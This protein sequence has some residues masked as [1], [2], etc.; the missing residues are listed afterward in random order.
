MRPTF[1]GFE[2]QKHT[3][4]IA[5][6]NLDIT[7][8]NISNINTPGYTRQR[9]DL[10]SMYVSGNRSLRW[11]SRTNNLS[12]QGQGVNA[13]GVSQLRDIFIDKRYRENVAVEAETTTKVQILTDIEDTLDNFETDGLQYHTQQFFNALQKYSVEKPDSADVAKIV[14]NTA[15]NLCQL[16]NAYDTELRQIEETY[17]NEL[18]DSVDYI[19]KIVEEMNVLNDKIAKEKIHYPEEY[20]PNELYDQMN[21]YIDEL[22]TYGNIEFWKNSNGT[23]SV[24]MANVEILN[25]EDFKTN[26]LIMKDYNDNGR[27]V[28]FFESGVDLNLTSG[29][30]KAYLDMI[31]GNGVYATGGQNSSYGIAYFKS[32]VDEFART[33]ATTFNNANGVE[34][35]PSRAMFVPDVEGALITAGNI[36]VSDSWQKDPTM[37]GQVR[38]FDEQRGIYR[39]G[40]DEKK[41]QEFTGEGDES[42][43][44]QTS[45]NVNLQNTN[46]KY[47]ISQF[48]NKSLK[49]GNCDDFEG[50]VYEY[51]SFVSNRLG[52]TIDYEDSRN[53]TATVTVDGLLDARDDVSGV[54]MDEE[55]INML[56][57]QKWYNASSRMVTTL[58]E[59]LDKLING[60]GRV[61]L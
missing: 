22:A 43:I 18:T 1:L 23:Y 54:Q 10:Y 5:Q 3:L 51:I 13:Y 19:N 52:Q 42:D 48:D 45:E 7:G 25:G 58:D 59:L 57:Y 24:K 37:I 8:N 60:T 20:G 16:L 31:N 61:G 35:D 6:K 11:S 27:A 26:R 2:T 33:V 41:D 38:I 15:V 21:L 9:V 36:H 56:N 4:Q 32:A 55:G 53:E 49:F 50:S 29:S 47:L 44:D 34:I 40:F 30:L 39:Y 28:V 12:M 14:T 46:V 17:V